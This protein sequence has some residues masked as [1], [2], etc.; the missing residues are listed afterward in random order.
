MGSVTP[1]GQ[2]E[3]KVKRIILY[4]II[5]AVVCLSP[6]QQLDVANLEP[7]QA[8]WVSTQDDRVRLETDT[9]DVGT[10]IT[11]AKALE[12][13]KNQS[14]G[15]VYLDTA[16]YLLVS[17]NAQTYIAELVPYLKGSV[18]VSLWSGEESVSSAAKY[19]QAH[20]TGLLLRKWQLGCPLETLPKINEKSEK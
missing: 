9:G 17:D 6:L 3:T 14:E 4:G 12:E 19:M 15:I 7:I 10:G 5:L 1:S 16:Q 18:K 2:E 8:V 20:H 11:V 13:M